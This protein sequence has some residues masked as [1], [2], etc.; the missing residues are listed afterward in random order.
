MS[1]EL[2]GHHETGLFRRARK[3]QIRRDAILDLVGYVQTPLGAVLAISAVAVFYFWAVDLRRLWSA[4]RLAE[5]APG[6][7]LYPP[8]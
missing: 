6:L 4:K 3:L 5:S 1:A 8:S 2:R 7:E